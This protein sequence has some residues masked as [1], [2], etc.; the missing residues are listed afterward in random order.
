M[1]PFIPEGLF[2]VSGTRPVTTNG[3]ST[4]DYVSL[5]NVE[6]CWIVVHLAQTVGHATAIT[7]NR[8]TAVAPTG[9]VAIGNAVP[10]WYGNVSTTSSQLA[11]QTDAVSYT[12]GA[13][14]TGDVYI[15]FQID[16][17][18]LGSTYDC[19]AAVSADS[20]QA[21]NFWEVTYWMKP[22]YASQVSSMDSDEYI[23]D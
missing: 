5:K 9:A 4:A 2:P 12:L 19:I 14:V 17:S 16:P 6:M 20:S 1:N 15:I 3:G 8:A 11:R 21:T 22:R 7:V 23:V 10:I 18:E 13:G